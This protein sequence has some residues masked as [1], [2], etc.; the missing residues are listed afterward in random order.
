MRAFVAI[1]IAAA[2]LLSCGFFSPRVGTESDDEDCAEYGCD[3]GGAEGGAGAV[4]FARDIRPIM[5]R[6]PNDP[7]GPGCAMCHYQNAAAPIGIQIGGLDLTTL[8]SLRRGGLHS[9]GTIAIPGRPDDSAIVQKL[10]GTYPYGVR[11]PKS[12]P[13]YLSDAEIQLVVDWIA[14]GAQGADSE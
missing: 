9:Q 12:G 2:P 14:Q 1:A 6:F 11:M 7:R 5:N 10:R 3:D 4:S 8:G 13:P